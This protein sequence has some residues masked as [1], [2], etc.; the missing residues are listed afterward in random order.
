[1]P[2]VEAAVDTFESAVTAERAG[3]G[4][5]ELCASLS[6][7]G[8][9]P[10]AG[11]IAAVAER[12]RIPVFVLVRPRGGD[13]D[14]T[15]AEIGIMLRDIQ[16]AKSLGAAGIVT[17]VLAGNGKIDVEKIR[18][19]VGVA[20]DLPVT[21]HRAFDYLPNLTEALDHLIEAGVARVLTSGG[22]NTAL[23]GASRIAALVKQSRGRIAIVAGGKIRENNVREVIALTGVSEVHAR[24]SAM[25][26]GD[27]ATHTTKLKL[28]KRL[29][30]NEHAWEE[31]DEARMRDLVSQAG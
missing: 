14:Y 6:D 19:L 4:R 3:A 29:P 24:I 28:R 23:E 12:C 7:G 5:I 16:L 11:L 25:V 18:V 31:L 30:D 2:L 8:I 22:A 17:G 20:K 9:T 10:S 13:F 26:G 27:G 21:F 1:L 15:G